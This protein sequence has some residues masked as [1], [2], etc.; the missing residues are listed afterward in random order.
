MKGFN[1]ICLLV[2]TWVV[3]LFASGPAAA[4]M[5]VTETGNV[6]IDVSNPVE[7]LQINGCI[8]GNQSG[9]LRINTPSGYTD[10]GAK[11][12]GF[13]HFTTDRTRFY[14]NQAV[15]VNSGLIGSY[16]ED[17]SLHTGG[18]TH[19][20]VK[21]SNG[22]VGINNTNPKSPL[23]VNGTIH[24]DFQANTGHHVNIKAMTAMEGGAI[25]LGYGGNTGFGEGPST[26]NIDVYGSDLRFFRYNPAGQA[27]VLMTL[28]EDGPVQIYGNL[29]VHGQVTWPDR[30]FKKGYRLRP[31]E[32][33][34]SFVG[35]NQRLP[36]IPSEQEVEERGVT[37]LDMFSKQMQKIEE[38]T[39]YLIDLKKENQ[40]L[41][42]R[43]A[44]MEKRIQAMQP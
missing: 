20:T 33:V 3:L 15:W 39:L 29:R 43:M 17:I 4:D 8:R 30:V 42:K 5:Y 18:T 27:A 11:N 7:K 25:T 2:T 41:K 14:F 40:H 10:I 13:S 35:Q 1:N 6:G 28:S 31:L 21:K 16:D 37:V 36:D 23:D 44:V 32:E 22:Y 9:A 24:T 26:W 12:A 34:A 38:L 19:V